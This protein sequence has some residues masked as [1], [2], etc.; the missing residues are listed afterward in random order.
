MW[1]G[2]RDA[3]C[4]LQPEDPLHFPGREGQDRVAAAEN[5]WLWPDGLVDACHRV[6]A[7]VVVRRIVLGEGIR[8]RTRSAAA[9]T[10]A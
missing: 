2:S 10:V 6:S 8:K 4:R 5:P 3:L 9:L 1:Q 7:S